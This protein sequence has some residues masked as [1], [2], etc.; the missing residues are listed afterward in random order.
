MQLPAPTE[1]TIV[2]SRLSP[3]SLKYLSES[4]MVSF[5]CDYGLGSHFGLEAMSMEVSI[6]GFIEPYGYY[7]LIIPNHC[8]L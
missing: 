7:F 3:L 5:S 6:S 1:I 4:W 8:E 2:T